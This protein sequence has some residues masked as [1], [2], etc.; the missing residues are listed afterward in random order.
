MA[1]RADAQAAGTLNALRDRLRG[2]YAIVNEA[3]DALA[4]ADAALRGGVRI[5]QYRAKRGVDPERAREMRRLTR[6]AGALFVI[7]DDWK[8][9]HEHDADGVH[10]GPED[11]SPAE[12]VAIRA[13]LGERLIGLSCGTPEEARAAHAAGADYAGAGAVYATQSKPDAGD[14]IGIAGL[15]R[16]AAASDL[17]VAAIGG[18]SLARIAEVRSSGVAMAAVISAIGAAADAERAAR[19]LVQAWAR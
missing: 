7:N 4:V 12:I 18:I 8:A 9:A 11:A 17:P 13:V 15:M 16:I 6:D 10:L 1:L 14:P 3:P 2:I 5:V 19:E